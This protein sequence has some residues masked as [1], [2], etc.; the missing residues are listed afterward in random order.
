VENQVKDFA[1]AKL[2]SATKKTRDS[3]EAVKKQVEEKAKKLANAGV[4]TTNLTIKNAK[5]PLR[6]E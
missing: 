1:K 6:K 3:L 5:I 2:D 4:D